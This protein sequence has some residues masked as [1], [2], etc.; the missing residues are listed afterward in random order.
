MEVT[1]KRLIDS[2][3]LPQKTAVPS[4]TATFTVNNDELLQGADV[5][6]VK[7]E[8]KTFSSLFKAGA[9]ILVLYQGL[10][11]GVQRVLGLRL[12]THTTTKDKAQNILKDGFLDPKYGGTS[13]SKD[14]NLDGYV[15][16]SKNHVHLTGVHSTNEHDSKSLKIP[17]TKTLNRKLTKLYYKYLANLEKCDDMREPGFKNAAKAI[18]NTFTNTGKAR[19][20]YASGTE[21]YFEKNFIA[22]VDTIALKSSEKVKVYKNRFSAIL[23]GVKEYG[24]KGISQNKAR[25]AAGIAILGGSAVAAY[26]LIKNA[27][28]NN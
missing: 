2:I 14:I 4:A 17:G 13:L 11:H 7:K 1:G 21:E 3:P 28:K 26:N 24:F 27:I 10:K 25:F 18:L 20:F 9:G 22:D 5:V 15:E 6:D 8:K 16:R 23:G 12:E 19:T